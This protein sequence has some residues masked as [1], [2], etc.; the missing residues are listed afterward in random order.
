MKE[1]YPDEHLQIVS[2][3]CTNFQKNPY[4][5]FLENA[6]KQ[7]MSTEVW[8]TDRQIDRRTRWNQYTPK[9]SFAGKGGIVIIDMLVPNHSFY[10]FNKWHNHLTRFVFHYNESVTKTAAE[11]QNRFD[12]NFNSKIVVHKYH[13]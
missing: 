2:N 5:H 12:Y 9:I 7:I 6:R 11:S 4:I 1:S 10:C 13:Y 8:Q 3:E